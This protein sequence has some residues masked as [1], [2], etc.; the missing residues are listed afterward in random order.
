ME[1]A[2]W[3][4]CKALYA[5]CDI[6]H[7]F[8]IPEQFSI[9]LETAGLMRYDDEEEEQEEEEGKKREKVE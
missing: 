1:K 7:E 3:Y 5:T 2:C 9:R 4:T 8:F 6:N